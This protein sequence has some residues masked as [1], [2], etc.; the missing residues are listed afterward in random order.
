MLSL[1]QR[2]GR[3][4]VCVLTDMDQ[5]LGRTVGNALEVREAA[6]TVRGEGPPDLTELVLDSCAHLLALSDLGIDAVEARRRAEAAVADGSAYAAYER[7]IRAQGGDPDDGALPKAPLV[8]EVFAPQDGYVHGLGAHAIGVAALHL[9]AGRR[10]KD[11]VIDH[12][13]GIVCRKK[14]G[15]EVTSGEALAEIHARDETSADEAAAD[16]LAAFE[17]GDEPPRAR[18]IV[19]DTI[20]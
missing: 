11:D 18:P 10:A 20:G 13:V 12:S 6:D 5:P 7:W 15:D 8:R 2:A 9:G 4:V 14:R 17:L 1:G 19:L 16:V 3:D